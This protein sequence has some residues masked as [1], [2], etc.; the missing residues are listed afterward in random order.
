MTYR[1]RILNAINFGSS[2]RVPY[3]LML[4]RGRFVPSVVDNFDKTF[5]LKEPEE[6]LTNWILI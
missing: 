3:A 6:I 2:D 4:G 5:G 1:E